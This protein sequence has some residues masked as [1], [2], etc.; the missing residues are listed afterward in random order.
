MRG[1]PWRYSGLAWG[2]GVMGQLGLA[3]PCAG[4]RA[5]LD[6][7]ARDGGAWGEL[8]KT[9]PRGPTR[10]GGVAVA[11]RPSPQIFCH[12]AM[13]HITQTLARYSNPRY[14][15]LMTKFKVNH[16]K[17]GRPPKPELQKVRKNLAEFISTNSHKLED[18]L[19]EIYERDGPK[20]AFDKFTDLLE[21]YVPKL[22]RQEHTGAD[23]GPVELSI[24]WSTDAK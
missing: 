13:L 19:D 16:G 15:V 10:L 5:G 6:E 23:E 17:G 9:P 21:F 4:L 18:W 2:H 3:W 7:F 14:L 1:E 20:V 24:K 12:F 8:S 11:I 22:A